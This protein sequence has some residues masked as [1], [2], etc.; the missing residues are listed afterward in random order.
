MDPSKFSYYIEGCKSDLTKVGKNCDDVCWHGENSDVENNELVAD[1]NVLYQRILMYIPV[2]I[3]DPDME[4]VCVKQN[5][6]SDLCIVDEESLKPG[7]TAV[8]IFIPHR[9]FYNL[10]ERE[11][12][13]YPSTADKETVERF[14]YIVLDHYVGIGLYFSHR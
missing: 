1:G 9:Y 13:F 4:Y 6:D 11:R 8:R 10:L 3:F 7:D 2:E 5:E 14:R 12:F